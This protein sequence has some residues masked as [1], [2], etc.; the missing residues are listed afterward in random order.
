MSPLPPGVR[1]DRDGELVV[2]LEATDETPDR[3]ST[4][5]TPPTPEERARNLR[6]VA[7]CRQALQDTKKE[8]HR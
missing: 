7:M 6:G 3:R 4:T 8:N 5:Y 1:R 2:D